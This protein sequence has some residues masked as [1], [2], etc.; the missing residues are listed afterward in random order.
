MLRAVVLVVVALIIGAAV[1]IGALFA[2]GI[3]AYDVT[4]EET[5]TAS[6]AKP[7]EK[8]NEPPAKKGPDSATVR[9]SGTQGVSYF[10]SYGSA[11]SGSKAIDGTL[12]SEP[13]DYEVPLEQTTTEVVHVSLHKRGNSPAERL[14]VQIIADGEVVKEQETEAESGDVSV[15]YYPLRGS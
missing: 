6:S 12:G 4:K 11:G 10:G 9:I 15:D 5:T 14:R 13:V 1:A 2:L 3:N 8:T 7:P